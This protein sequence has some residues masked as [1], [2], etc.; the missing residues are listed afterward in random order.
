M[1]TAAGS[2]GNHLN[3]FD[4]HLNMSAVGTVWSITFHDKFRSGVFSF[5]SLFFPIFFSLFLFLFFSKWNW[6]IIHQ[7]F[8]RFTVT[9]FVF[10]F[11]G[12]LN[13]TSEICATKTLPW[14]VF[15]SLIHSDLDF[16]LEFRNCG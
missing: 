10:H 11:T 6:L 3:K 12:D 4:R 7:H 5:S 15:G 2:E 8:F 13:L 1:L 14:L 16:Y 9:R